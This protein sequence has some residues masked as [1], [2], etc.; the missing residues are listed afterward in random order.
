ML[1]RTQQPGAQ[2]PG[3]FDVRVGPPLRTARRRSAPRFCGE[4]PVGV[5]PKRLSHQKPRRR[6]LHHG[7]ECAGDYNGPCQGFGP[8]GKV[9]ANPRRR[10]SRH[11]FQALGCRVRLQPRGPGGAGPEAVTS[12]GARACASPAATDSPPAFQRAAPTAGTWAQR[13]PSSKE[14]VTA[15][16]RSGRWGSP[17]G[18]LA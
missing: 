7:D 12:G 6:T 15:H 9:S 5:H 11:R 2:A 3:R 13:Q 4:C 14:R 10:H 1:V 8:Q 16:R 18:V 17:Q